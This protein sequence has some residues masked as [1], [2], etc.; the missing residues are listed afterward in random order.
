MEMQYAPFI[1]SNL[2]KTFGGLH[3]PRE[4]RQMIIEEIKNGHAYDMA[5]LLL[6]SIGLMDIWGESVNE[7]NHKLQEINR[8]IT[9]RNFTETE[10]RYLG[11]ITSLLLSVATISREE[12]EEL[13]RDCKDKL[14]FTIIDHSFKPE[15]DPVDYL[16]D[17][18]NSKEMKALKETYNLV[19]S[20]LVGHSKWYDLGITEKQMTD[21]CAL[22]IDRER[23]LLAEFYS[24]TEYKKGITFVKLGDKYIRFKNKSAKTDGYAVNG[25]SELNKLIEC[26]LADK[27]KYREMSAEKWF[28]THYKKGFYIAYS[29]DILF[30]L[31]SLDLKSV[32]KSDVDYL[33]FNLK[34]LKELSE[35]VPVYKNKEDM[36]KALDG[37]VV[38]GQKYVCVDRVFKGNKAVKFIL[39]DMAGNKCTVSREK[40]LYE[41]G[42][43]NIEVK[44][45][46]IKPQGKIVVKK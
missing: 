13:L 21:I 32:L 46:V 38:V 11:Q 18:Y 26:G 5:G 12:K 9:E 6:A 35:Y 40:L 10:Y 42:I 27:V 37:K 22:A 36:L 1:N 45:V 17:N 34:Q 14:W 4:M 44:N 30:T 15:F 19:V 43:G 29:N 23:R 33:R 28:K 41:V 39:K 7:D 16:L 25:R 3:H 8:A 20:A 2:I 31:Y 24:K